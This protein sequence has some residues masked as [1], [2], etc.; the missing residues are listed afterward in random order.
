MPGVT[1]E[2]I[3]RAWEIDLLSYLST[4]EPNEL[5]RDGPGRYTTA[6]HGSLVI[7]N[8]KWNWNGGG[9]AGVSALD[10]L[11]KVRGMGFV[12]AVE[13]LTGERAESVRTY[14]AVTK[15]QPAPER[16][17]FYPP[18][19]LKYPNGAVAYSQQP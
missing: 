4:Y 12:S 8:G 14:Q 9:I 19:P 16:I 2:Q 13:A 1:E 15:T 5:I 3:S 18:R 6:T 17:P 10:Y 11:A 7:S